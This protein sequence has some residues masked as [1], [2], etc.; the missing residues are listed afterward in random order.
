[1]EPIRVI[2]DEEEYDECIHRFRLD[3]EYSTFVM[4]ECQI[5]GMI[6]WLSSSK[7]QP[8]SIEIVDLNEREFRCP[9][10][11]TVHH[12]APEVFNWVLGVSDKLKSDI[13][14]IIFDYVITIPMRI[15]LEF[16]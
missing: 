1:M 15:L 12:I 16:S 10:C 11:R 2:T 8:R 4:G 7:K 9:S 6:M 14:R 3:T 5:C 13:S